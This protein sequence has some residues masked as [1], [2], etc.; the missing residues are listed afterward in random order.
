MIRT[1][2]A[3]ITVLTLAAPVLRADPKD[4]IQAAIQKLGDSPSYSW[5]TNISGG[6]GRGTQDGKTQKDGYSTVTMQ[7]RDSSFDIVIKGVKTVLKTDSGW[8]TPSEVISD[9]GGDN[10]GGPPGP[11]FL[12]AIMARNFKTPA[13]QALDNIDALSNIQKT[14]N[15]YTADLSED[16]IKAM[17]ARPRRPS[18]TTNP[19]AATSMPSP[20][21]S[22]A[23]GNVKITISGGNLTQLMVH[24]TAT[25][26]INGNDRDVDRT[27]TT[28]FKDV[29]STTVDVPDDAKAKLAS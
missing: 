26:T 8:K 13:Q 6:F 19:D 5:S 25:I 3:M 17:V 27:T 9:E 16:A 15:G 23:S 14:D 24:V 7:I 20:N 12:A 18:A 22:N 10:A 29:G 2:L 1:L 4:D 28:T 21:I 11:E